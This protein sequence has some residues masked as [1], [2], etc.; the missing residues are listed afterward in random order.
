[1]KKKETNWN[2]LWPIVNVL[3]E[4]CNGIQLHDLENK[5]GF[6]RENIIA[7]MDKMETHQVD[8]SRSEES[9]IIELDDHEINIINKCFK[10]VLK[11]IEEWE[12]QTRIGITIDKATAII[13]KLTG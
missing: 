3:N 7:L 4:V 1:M 9:A 8:E 2:E 13:N 5:L 6:N 11:E 12:F 10:E